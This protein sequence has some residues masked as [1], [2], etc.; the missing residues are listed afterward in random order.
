MNVLFPHLFSLFFAILFVLP[1]IAFAQTKT[2]EENTPTVGATSQASFDITS[3]W[4]ILVNRNGQAQ[5][6]QIPEG[7]NRGTTKKFL[8][9][10]ISN[11]TK[12][13]LVTIDTEMIETAHSRILILSPQTGN[14]IVV[15]QKQ[16]E[17]FEGTLTNV[18]GQV[19]SVSLQR[20]SEN[21][22]AK[23]QTPFL[24]NP[25]ITL[26]GSAVPR[27]CANFIGGW[28]GVWNSDQRYLWVTEISQAC[29]AQYFYSLQ[30]KKAKETQ[31]T[32]IKDGVLTVPCGTLDGV[33]RF[34]YHGDELWA[35][36]IGSDGSNHT[37]FKKITTV[38]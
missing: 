11:F 30:Q 27:S 14:R 20:L 26:P 25:P 2:T 13:E 5:A 9:R 15:A 28:A 18:Q 6:L 7:T 37:V 23:I 16:N 29:V 8:L 36:Y 33:C 32:E 17:S 31:P 4:R 38:K 1:N 34:T 3:A 24:T 12:G 10:V 19:F 22:L 21:E 35:N